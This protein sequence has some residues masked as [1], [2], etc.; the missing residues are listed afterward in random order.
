MNKYTIFPSVMVA[1]FLQGCGDSPANTA[2][3]N[4]SL[5]TFLT[6]HDKYC[7]AEYTS[8]EHL[9]SVLQENPEFQESE[10]YDGIFEKDVAS[11]SYAVSPE[12]GGCT[13]DLK[14]RTT[15]KSKAFFGF[16]D[17]NNALLTKGY[18]TKGE[19]EIRTELGL[20]NRELKVVEQKYE[21]KDSTIST[22]VF[23]LENEDQY[24]MTLFVEKFEIQGVSLKITSPDLV[25]I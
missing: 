15:S 10:S 22:L 2:S 16:E 13:T 4:E 24:Y 17:I 5:S 14:I 9:T 23:P 25:E 3:T 11:I 6:L 20:D 8:A 21:S 18:R 19:K 12:E 7:G 1:L